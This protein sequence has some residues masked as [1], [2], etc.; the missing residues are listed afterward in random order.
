MAELYSRLERWRRRLGGAG[1]SVLTLALVALVGWGAYR[2]SLGSGLAELRARGEHRLD[3]HAAALERELSRYAPVPG[4]L[5]LDQEVLD[6]LAD[7]GRDAQ[8]VRRANLFLE[9]LNVRA[10]TGVIYLMDSQG[11]VL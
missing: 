4:I 3:L 6:L 8:R 9:R 7:G 10:G 2:W 1:V 11:R 5:G